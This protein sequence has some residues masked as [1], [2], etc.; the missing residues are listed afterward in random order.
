MSRYS[1]AV[2]P[3]SPR[4]VF[5]AYTSPSR[6]SPSVTNETSGQG[7][8]KI[9]GTIV[10]YVSG[11]DRARSTVGKRAPGA[12]PDVE[13]LGAYGVWK[14]TRFGYILAVANANSRAALERRGL[15]APSAEEVQAAVKRYWRNLPQSE[16]NKLESQLQ[17]LADEQGYDA[18]EEEVGAVSYSS[19]RSPTRRSL[20]SYRSPRS[21][22]SGR[23]TGLSPVQIEDEGI[24]SGFTGS[25]ARQYGGAEEY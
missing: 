13:E 9:P 1:S 17:A 6:F 14:G 7:L 23:R 11:T 3:V 2:S 12:P 19:Y 24:G 18:P 10:S 15:P 8:Y 20:T 22:G 16:Y 4:G 21:I 5:G 25:Y